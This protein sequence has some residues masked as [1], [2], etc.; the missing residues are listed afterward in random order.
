MPGP[1]KPT[2]FSS[3]LGVSAS[4]GAG[5]PVRGSVMID[6]LMMAPTRATSM[7]W[8]SSRPAPAQPEAASTGLGS[9]VCPSLV[10]RSAGMLAPRVSPHAGMLAPRVSPHARLP[11]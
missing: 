10:R 6:L 1:C 9:S 11:R 5:L 2:E 8:A 3:P 7:N 4:R